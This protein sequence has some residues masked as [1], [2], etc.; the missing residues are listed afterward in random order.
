[1]P[2]TKFVVRIMFTGNTLEK[3]RTFRKQNIKALKSEF[4]STITEIVK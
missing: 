1:M 2:N 3:Y 4:K